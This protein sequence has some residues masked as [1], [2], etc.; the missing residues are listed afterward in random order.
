M[1]KDMELRLSGEGAAEK[2]SINKEDQA[3]LFMPV[4]HPRT[5]ERMDEV[6]IPLVFHKVRLW[7]LR[8]LHE[9]AH[10]SPEETGSLQLY[11]RP[12]DLEEFNRELTE[13][14]AKRNQRAEPPAT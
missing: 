8:A 7:E 9:T 5:K 13:F 11:I 6:G 10:D 12:G 4:V 14:F 3:I 1:N 2:P